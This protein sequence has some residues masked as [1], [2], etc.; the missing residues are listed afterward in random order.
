MSKYGRRLIWTA[1]IPTRQERW[2]TEFSTFHAVQTSLCSSKG[3]WPHTAPFSILPPVTGICGKIIAIYCRN[4][5]VG[6]P[7]ISPNPCH[8]F[9]GRQGF[10]H[11]AALRIYSSRNTAFVFFDFQ[12]KEVTFFA[13]GRFKNFHNW[14]SQKQ[15]FFRVTA[16]FAGIRSFTEANARV[17]RRASWYSAVDGFSRAIPADGSCG[18]IYQIPE[19]AA[20]LFNFFR[21][22]GV[23][24]ISANF[25][26]SLKNN[27]FSNN[28]RRR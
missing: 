8:T 9:T 6:T 22:S 15:M 2:L 20:A 23:Q 4:L 21:T 3:R 16:Y 24:N 25:V 7:R 18:G 27:P 19:T 5:S 13:T 11:C 10:L 1:N 17:Y 14:N 12:V 26:S 28:A